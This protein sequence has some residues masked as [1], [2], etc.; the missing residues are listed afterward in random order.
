MLS[1][2]IRV[3]LSGAACAR[4]YKLSNL[5]PS[6][7]TSLKMRFS[8]SKAN[9]DKIY[10]MF[11]LQNNEGQFIQLLVI[12]NSIKFVIKL[13]KEE[14]EVSMDLSGDNINVNIERFIFSILPSIKFINIIFF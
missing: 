4:S 14:K 13:Q 2:Q 12:Q 9:P 5:E 6:L 1:L 7:I 3:S 10:S 8:L 11:L